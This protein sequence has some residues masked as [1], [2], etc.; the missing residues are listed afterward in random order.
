MHVAKRNSRS[1][2]H[3]Y[4][5]KKLHS[6]YQWHHK[7]HTWT[8]FIFLLIS[9]SSIAKCALGGKNYANCKTL[10]QM[11]LMGSGTSLKSF[12]I[13]APTYNSRK[14]KIM[15]ILNVPCSNLSP[16]LFCRRPVD[17]AFYRCVALFALEKRSTT[18]NWRQTVFYFLCRKR[19]HRVDVIIQHQQS[20]LC[21]LYK[22]NLCSRR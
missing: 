22:C 13:C 19:A 16:A 8:A 1:D 20:S 12:S 15:T 7:V 21:K 6:F 11:R 2:D 17:E 3:H 4:C 9:F 5:C 14:S 10:P 18:L